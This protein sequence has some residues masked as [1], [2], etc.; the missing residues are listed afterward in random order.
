MT[1]T[2]DLAR[3]LKR[4][5]SVLFYHGVEPEII[6][7]IVQETHISFRNFE[8]QIDY[9]RKNYE[10]ISLND[11]FD[12]ISNGYKLDPSYVLLTF[13]DGYKN[14]IGIVEP[15]LV[16]YGIPFS[17]F[18]STGYIG[19]GLRMPYYKLKAALLHTEKN[20]IKVPSIGKD[21]DISTRAKRISCIN[22]MVVILKRS[23]REKVERINKDLTTLIQEDRWLE[24]DSRYS[25]ERFMDWH[26][27]RKLHEAG[28]TIGSH[29]H[30]HAILHS[31]QDGAEIVYQLRNSK[32]LIEQNVGQCRYFSYPN[33]RM[34]DISRHSP[35]YVKKNNYSLGFST[36]AGEI[37][38]NRFN[39]YLL[40]RIFPRKELDAFKFALNTSFLYNYKYFS[41]SSG[42]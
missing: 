37:V 6:D 40:P 41:W 29:C 24:L 13:D 18:I 33:G 20:H 3:R 9:L 12:C 7:P 14:N 2:F 1:G 35:G 22:E 27:V 32:Y 11:L 36:V 39:P 31:Q 17:V 28:V 34:S 19:T 10:I 16:T 8:K 21:L 42:F 38:N 30:D 26:D 5:V 4:G 23:S 15:F 25:S